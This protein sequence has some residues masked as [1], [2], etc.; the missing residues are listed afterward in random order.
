M[1]NER[2]DDI[3]YTNNY[4]IIIGWRL[5]TTVQYYILILY[6]YNMVS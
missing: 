4:T 6:Y 5:G 1:A 2:N 3:F